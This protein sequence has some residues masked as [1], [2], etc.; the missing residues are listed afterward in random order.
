MPSYVTPL[1]NSAFVFYVGLTSQ[2]DTK[3]FQTNPTLAAGDFQVSIDGGGL[4]N[5]ATLPD[6]D[7]NASKLV[8]ISL[9]AA[10]MNGDN[11][12]VIG[13]DAAGAEWCDIAINIQTTLQQIDNLLGDLLTLAEP[14]GAPAATATAAVKLGRLHQVLRNK[15]TVTATSKAFFNDAGAALWSKT[16]S[17]DGVTYTENEGS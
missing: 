14:T 1:K 11:I 6:V 3:L 10:E 17:D 12:Q 16:L 15:L 7:P 4:G 5:L 13:S 2:A 8:K 9:S